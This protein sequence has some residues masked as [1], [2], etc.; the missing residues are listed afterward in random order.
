M[1][2]QSRSLIFYLN[3]KTEL[4]IYDVYQCFKGFSNIDFEI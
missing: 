1:I 2:K 3:D 4:Y